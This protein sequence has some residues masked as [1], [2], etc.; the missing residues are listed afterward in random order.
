M[1]ET[2]LKTIFQVRRDLDTNWAAS[3]YV[4][5]DGEPAFSID[6]GIFKVG[7]GSKTWKDLDPINDKTTI[8][9]I[10]ETI[11]TI[12]GKV[13]SLEEITGS[14]S[15]STGVS[16]LDRIKTLEKE[17]GLG[18]ESGETSSI[19][20]RIE[21]IEKVLYT[22]GE[23]GLDTVV[24]LIKYVEDH[25]ATTDAIIKKLNTIEEGAQVN[26][27]ESI[28]FNGKKVEIVDKEANIELPTA[29]LETLGTVKSSTGANKV[30][31]S[32]DGTMKVSKI[33]TTSLVTPVGITLVFDSGSAT[34]DTDDYDTVI[35]DIPYASLADAVNAADN[36]D[37]VTLSKDV[38]LG[39]DDIDHLV[40]DA[41]NVTID[42][43]NHT[44]TANGSNGAIKVEGG[45]TV[46]EGE[47]GAVNATLGSDAYSMAV[48]ADDGLVVINN[49]TY[50]NATDGSERGTDLVYASGTATIEINGGTFIAAKP[51]WTLNCKDVD[52]KAG[53]AKIVVKGGRF[54][55]FDPANNKTE[56]NGTNYVA[57]GYKSTKDGDYYVVTAL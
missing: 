48:W 18:E 14:G 50:T 9:T 12:E 55:Q 44:V 4:L 25:G 40:V 33:S 5:R 52:Y 43:G 41:E 30:N 1:A 51:E 28:I 3:T 38:N 34:E 21:A 15:S 19:L 57:E 22:T 45:V 2:V 56:G 20:E 49:G 32:N 37:V 23:E 26:T 42:L 47:N 24:D 6:T 31:V 46:L 27:I 39:T 53:T 11:E 35:G 29:N 17:L 13:T 36:G 7:D 54:Y 8:E 10:V 16:L